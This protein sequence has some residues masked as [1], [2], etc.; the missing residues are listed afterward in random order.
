M[1]IGDVGKFQ[2]FFR[3]GQIS[4]NQAKNERIKNAVNAVVIQSGRQIAAR[5]AFVDS[6]GKKSNKNAAGPPTA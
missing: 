1:S 5:S 6:P 3:S 2:K 4:L